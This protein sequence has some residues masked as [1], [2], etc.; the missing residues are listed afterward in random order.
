M[1]LKLTFSYDGSAFLGSASQPHNKGVQNSLNQA[2][3]H[4]GITQIPLF[5]S[6]TDKGVHASAAVASVECGEHFKDLIYLKKQINKF[7]HPHIH[8]KTIKQV[9]ENFEVR[10]HAKAREYRYIFSHASFSPF[11]APYVYFY[12][13]FDIVKANHL[14]RHFLGEND[15]KFFQKSGSDTQT[16]VREMLSVKAYSYKEFSVFKFRANGFLR[17]QIRLSVAS[18]LAVL[19]GRLREEQLKEQIAAQKCHFRF[20]APPSGLY[21]SR[22]FY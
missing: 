10:F 15:F 13:Q 19:E 5:A 18:V 9:N 14:L 3:K 11:L 1:K 21:L 22:I 6:R 12:P 17:A 4:L 20:L 2:L 8:I 16:S 7:A